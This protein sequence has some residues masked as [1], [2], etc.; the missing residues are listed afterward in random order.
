MDVTYDGKIKMGRAEWTKHSDQGSSNRSYLVE[1]FTFV[2]D[3]P[4]TRLYPVGG[5]SFFYI[6]VF[7]S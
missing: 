2:F 3:L 5:K 4:R 7:D 6:C 1:Y